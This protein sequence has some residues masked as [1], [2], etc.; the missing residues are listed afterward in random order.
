[1]TKQEAIEQLDKLDEYWSEP[2]Y[3]VQD[4]GTIYSG[5]LVPCGC[6]GAHCA[7]ALNARMRYFKDCPAGQE[8]VLYKYDV[9]DGINRLVEITRILGEDEWE[10]HRILELCSGVSQPFSTEEWAVHPRK[11]WPLISKELRRLAQ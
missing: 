4:I 11:A 9:C 5:D 10:L 8:G 3:V 2:R 6:F 7:K 1:M